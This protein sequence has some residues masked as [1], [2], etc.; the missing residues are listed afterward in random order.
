MQH[1]L[2]GVLALERREM[3]S[4]VGA[5]GKTS[6]V[7]LLTAELSTGGARVVVATTTAMFARELAAVGPLVMDADD[8]VLAA[9]LSEALE[10]GR[11]AGAARAPGV[12]GKVVGLPPATVDGLWADG[13]AD[14]V[15]VE[16]DGSRGM[17]LKAFGPHEPQV[18]GATSTIVL[19]AGLDAIG[20]PLTPEYVHRADV[21]AA[22]LGLSLGAPV[23]LRAFVGALREQVWRL[24]QGWPATRVVALLNKADGRDEETLGGQVA[25]ELLTGGRAVHRQP[26]AAG[27]QGPDAVIVASLRRERFARVAAEADDRR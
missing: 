6:A 11:V 27:P 10:G 18:P 12:D 7:R 26:L 15:L 5:G 22:G 8:A 19:V 21:L 2:A 14:Y 3:V 4:L 17:P 13:L 25:Q 9:R 1:T 24:R 23:T 16:A 20:R